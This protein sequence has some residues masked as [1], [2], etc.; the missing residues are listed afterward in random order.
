MGVAQ[1]TLAGLE[2]KI[3]SAQNETFPQQ[4]KIDLAQDELLPQQN[5][6]QQ[7]IAKH[8]VFLDKNIISPH[9]VPDALPFRQKQIEQISTAL[10]AT[11]QGKKA[12]NVFIYGKVGTGKTVT[13]KHVLQ[14]L[15]QFIEQSNSPVGFA[16][17]NC[18]NHNSKY[19]VLLKAMQRFYPKED[20]I[21]Y[22]ASFVF[23]KLLQVA[24]EKGKNLI[25][26]LDEID[27]AKDLDELVYSL[28]RAND[29][30]PFG[31]ISILGISNNLF[32]KERLDARTKSAL[33]EK[34]MVFPPYNAEELKAILQE[35]VAKAFKPGAVSTSA[36]NLAAAIAAQETGDARTAIMLLLR[37][38]EEADKM[39][40]S[41]VTDVMVRKAK[42]S[43]E[44]EVILNMVAT[45]PKQQQLVLYAI[46][47]LTTQ[48]K[49]MQRITSSGQSE[50]GVFCS[51][52]LYNEYKRL[53]LSLNESVVSSRWFREYINELDTYGLLLTTASGKG[54][55]G[56]TTLIKLGFDAKKLRAVLEKEL[57]GE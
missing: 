42:A 32:F 11:L 27:K 22:S 34:E 24:A 36:I 37:A 4:N 28:T 17:V 13:V 8:T 40:F 16:F 31:S 26:V 46:S 47:L 30:L 19:K 53:A 45:L 21:G 29:E 10:A 15:Q 49:G 51:G 56:A 44:Q 3:D 41:E 9:Y 2:Q 14:Q 25:I 39:Q 12:D 43:V 5:I 20:F 23:E 38:G 33:L 48:G 18:R 7:F 35:R 1:Q 57:M 55:R 50:E 52:D 6:F 54:V